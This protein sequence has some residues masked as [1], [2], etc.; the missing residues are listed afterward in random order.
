MNFLFNLQIL[1]GVA[2]AMKFLFQHDI[3]H[4]DVK[5]GNI[6]LRLKED[7]RVDFAV[8]CDLGISRT[9]EASGQSN[10]TYVGSDPW[11]APE[12]KR[13]INKMKEGEINNISEG[14]G[15]PIDVFGFGLVAQWLVTGNNPPARHVKGIFDTFLVFIH[16]PSLLSIRSFV[17]CLLKISNW[18]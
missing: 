18:V 13:D 1:F 3:V 15:H 11:M 14:Y 12:I 10:L 2:S 8:L 7:E 5:P 4:R 6:L 16:L 9:I 17:W